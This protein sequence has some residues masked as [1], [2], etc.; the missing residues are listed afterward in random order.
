MDG[1]MDGWVDWM[2]PKGVYRA[3]NI[4]FQFMH[5]FRFY[6]VAPNFIGDETKI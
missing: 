4:C 2:A 3:S 1:Q 5:L 6:L